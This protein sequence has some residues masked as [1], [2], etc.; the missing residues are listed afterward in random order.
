[1]CI[2]KIWSNLST[3]SG[4]IAVTNFTHELGT[5]DANVIYASY[6]ITNSNLFVIFKP[7]RRYGVLNFFISESDLVSI[8]TLTP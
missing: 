2:Y 6:C 3:R 1:M 7:L 5:D 4:V 8:L